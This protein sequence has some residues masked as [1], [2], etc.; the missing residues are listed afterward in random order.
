MKSPLAKI[1]S[2]F[3]NI[4]SFIDLQ[5]TKQM[6]IRHSSMVNKIDI[7]QIKLDR[8]QDHYLITVACLY[9]SFLHHQYHWNMMKPSRKNSKNK[10]LIHSK[11]DLY[12]T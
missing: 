12:K 5:E 11:K 10:Y 6:T 4:T 3:S 1:N 7:D 9:N 2:Q 8:H